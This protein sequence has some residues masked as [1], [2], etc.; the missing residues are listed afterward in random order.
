M[1][2]LESKEYDVTFKVYRNDDNE[3]VYVV[4]YGWSIKKY[5]NFDIAYDEFDKCMCDAL[6]AKGVMGEI[7]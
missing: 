4:I 2:I 6:K 1:I 5:D 7:I 3:R